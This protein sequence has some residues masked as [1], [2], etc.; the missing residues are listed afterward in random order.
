MQVI[1]FVKVNSPL[2]VAS[3]QIETRTKRENAAEAT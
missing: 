2:A 3:P 1:D